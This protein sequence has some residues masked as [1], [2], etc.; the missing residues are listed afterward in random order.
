MPEIVKSGRALIG[1]IEDWIAVTPTLWWLG[2]AGFAMRFA[3]I[4][5][6]ID[7]CFSTPLGRVRRHPSPLNP[8]DI[9]RADMIF[10]THAH[11]GH[12]D[13]PSI[14]AMLENSKTAKV[15]LPKSAVEA[16]PQA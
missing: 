11:P 16:G 15:A 4:T 14:A 10:A 5:F 1:E 3:N 7:P 2:H 6:Y 13:A 8:T 12:L 9:R